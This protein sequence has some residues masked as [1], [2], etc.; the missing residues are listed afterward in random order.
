MFN[1]RTAYTNSNNFFGN[2]SPAELLEKFG[3]PLYVYNENILRQRCQEMRTL[4]DH[5]RFIPSYST[6]ANGNPSLLKIIKESGLKADAMSPGE[7]A[8][9]QKAGFSKQD[10]TYVCNNVSPEE[11]AFA[12]E[13][14]AHVSVDSLSQLES[15]GKVAFGKEVM[16]RVNPGKGAGHHAKVVTA[17]ANTKFGITAEDL[18]QVNAILQKYKLKLVG[19]N[20][21]VGSL[22]MESTTYVQAADWLLSTAEQFPSLEIIDFGGGFGIPYHKYENQPRLDLSKLSRELSE[23]VNSWAKRTHYQ[24]AF[25]TEPGR[26][27]VAESGLTLGRVTATKNNGAT[28]YVGTDIGFSVLARPIMYDAFHDVEIY[29][30]SGVE[31]PCL[32]QT[33]VGNICETGDVLAAKRLLPEF[34]EGDIIG[35]LDTGAYG[36][37]MSSQYN[38]RFRPAEVLI[39]NAGEAV[40]IRRRDKLEDILQPFCC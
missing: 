32:E 34:V 8:L 6:K 35:M 28:R 9:V 33:I 19:L 26:Y 11:L 21:H 23:L 30:S 24:G 20:Q 3:S 17:G 31:K 2:T 37:S 10:I 38:Q 5:P 1:T 36:H 7:I 22:F 40:Q 14:A 4:I 25:V 29:P 13:S 27:A 12:A 15:F 16:I 39:N 18:P